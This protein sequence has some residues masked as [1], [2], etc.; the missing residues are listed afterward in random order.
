MAKITLTVEDLPNGKVEVRMEPSFETLMKM[1]ISG[2]KLTS[3]HGYAMRMALEARKVSKEQ[4]NGNIIKI[5]GFTGR[6]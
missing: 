4:G 3:A 5:P 1:D 2:H 6:A